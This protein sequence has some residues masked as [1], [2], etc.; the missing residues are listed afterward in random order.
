MYVFVVIFVLKQVSSCLNVYILA[1]MGVK[2]NYT[3]DG[4]NQELFLKC[5]SY[6]NASQ[7]MGHNQRKHCEILCFCPS[8][9]N[10][11]HGKLNEIEFGCR[12]CRICHLGRLSAIIINVLLTS[13]AQHNSINTHIC[14]SSCIWMIGYR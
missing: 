3:V 8:K 11:V 14:R 10:G 7:N 12:F 4:Q 9:C 13:C 2:I 5:I 6:G 1:F